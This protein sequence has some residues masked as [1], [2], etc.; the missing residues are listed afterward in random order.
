MGSWCQ[1]F[2]DALCT[3][4]NQAV[5][6]SL[7]IKTAPIITA[8]GNYQYAEKNSTT[9]GTAPIHIYENSLTTLPHN[10]SARRVPLS[11]VTNMQ[12]NDFG[13]TLTI[14][15]GE[16]YSFN[17]LGYT[18]APFCDAVEKQIR[19]L[20]ANSLSA[21][22][23]F[24]PSL[25]VT[26][27]SQ[28]A[29]IMPLGTTASFGNL[30]TIAPSF[31]KAI[32]SKLLDTSIAEYYS[33]FRDLCDPAQI[34]LGFRKTKVATDN[35]K[36]APSSLVDSSNNPMKV[37]NM[38][39][40]EKKEAKKAPSDQYSLWLVVPSPNGQFA[41]VE[42]AEEDSATFVYNTSNGFN[43]FVLQLNHALEAIN[44]QREVIR[45]SNEEL[46]KPEYVDYYM[47]SKRTASLQF[48]RSNFKSRLIHNN[49]EH[50]KKK[51]LELWNSS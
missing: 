40:E 4:Y 10:L 45:L 12:K 31:A 42:F 5:L 35:T 34:H 3:A 1:P 8:N 48:I 33:A 13:L 11:F 26:Q 18:T 37:K 29:R 43:E 2:H 47:A 14:D 21:I 24:D 17:K 28:I 49:V 15:T 39:T 25:S 30:S 50:W 51:L 16:S 41:T 38:L 23:E 27:A 9:S 6:R 7:F 32:E 20:R 22:K 44:Y 19:I 36:D 46:R